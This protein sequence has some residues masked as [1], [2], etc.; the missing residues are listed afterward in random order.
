MMSLKFDLKDPLFQKALTHKSYKSTHKY[1]GNNERL[2]FLGDAVLDLILSEYLMDEHPKA[3]EGTLSLWRA[4]LVNIETLYEVGTQLELEKKILLGK[5][6]LKLGCCKNKRI[7]AST[8]EAL[9]GA[10]HLKYGLKST[11]K[12]VIHLFKSYLDK[13]SYKVKFEKDYKTRL[14]EFFQKKIKRP[15]YYK[16]IEEEGPPHKKTFTVQ[17][18][19]DKYMI[20]QGEGKNKKE[21]SQNA[22]QKAMEKLPEIETLL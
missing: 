9:I 5:S 21:A 14:Q 16:I 13:L 8:L 1:F 20:S 22:A 12:I 2:E 18:F 15:P 7:I 10:F 3:Q 6:E 4:S 17:I 11:K 19:F